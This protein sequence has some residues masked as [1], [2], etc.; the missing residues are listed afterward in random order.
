MDLSPTSI[1]ALDHAL[2]LAKKLKSEIYLLHVKETAT[3]NNLLTGI[4]KKDLKEGEKDINVV[5][6]KFQEYIDE[7][8]SK[9]GIRTY[10]K[11]LEGTVYIQ[12]L[13]YA[14][15]IS[16]GLICMGTHG[17]KG[18][19]NF[20][21]GSNTF[22]VVNQAKCPVLS[23]HASSG[24]KGIKDIVLPLD[25]SR[26]TREKVDDAAYIA[27]MFNSTIHVVGVS[28]SSDEMILN[29]LRVVTKQVEDYIIEDKI[30]TS[31]GFRTGKNLANLTLDYAKEKEADLII[32]MTEQESSA[33]FLAGPYSQ[34]MINN[35]NVPIL[36]VR[37][38][39][40]ETEFVTPY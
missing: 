15:E 28:T 34:Q 32:I 25:S 5:E 29:R 31:F 11:F 19:E 38:R 17:S 14:K 3:V 37:P 18:V 20:I 39:E 36:S 27:K 7:F 23:I 33:G 22:R 35:S 13:N 9:H 21:G 6:V 24:T 1:L 10:M 2:Y 26:D 40:R 4:F 8:Q 12:V 16:A 30:N